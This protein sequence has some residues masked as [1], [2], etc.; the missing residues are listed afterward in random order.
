[1]SCHE[2]KN[3]L[4]TM[5]LVLALLLVFVVGDTANVCA[6]DNDDC[7]DFE[8]FA[9]DA[10]T[11]FD[12]ASK[13][14]L[15][16]LNQNVFGQKPKSKDKQGQPAQ[17]RR[18]S[19]SRLVNKDSSSS[20]SSTSTDE[21]ADKTSKDDDKKDTG[22]L[23][24]LADIAK[25][26]DPTEALFKF[27]LDKSVV[28]YEEEYAPTFKDTADL[29]TSHAKEVMDQL[30][31]VL[32]DRLNDLMD[33]C[34]FLP[35]AWYLLRHEQAKKHAYWKSSKHKYMTKVNDV[36]LWRE[37]HQAL[38][39]SDLAYV[40]EEQQVRDGLQ[41]CDNGNWELIFVDTQGNPAEPAH[42]VAVEKQMAP[43]NKDAADN[44]KKKKSFWQKAMAAGEEEESD[45]LKVMIVVRGTKTMADVL[46]DGLLEATTFKEKY[47][48]HGGIQKSGAYIVEKHIERL[49]LL[50]EVSGRSKIELLLFGHSLGCGTAAIAAMEFHD[51]YQDILSVSAVGFGCPALVSPE[52]SEQYKDIITTVV[53]DADIVPR[54][55]GSSIVNLHLEMM[56]F[57]WTKYLTEEL[58]ELGADILKDVDQW[59]SGHGTKF[60]KD[61]MG[62]LGEQIENYLDGNIRPKIQK[63]VDESIPKVVGNLEGSQRRTL[64]EKH[65]YR[66]ETELIP[67]G[68]CLHLYRTATGF[69]AAYTPCSFFD[70]IEYV[71]HLVED[72]L[73]ESGYHFALLSLLRQQLRDNNAVFDNELAR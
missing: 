33:E 63:A 1:M 54:M 24:S 51:N 59:T 16:F 22:V 43:M 53:A 36:G 27:L 14:S 38:Y 35:S 39:L 4:L 46:S 47:K 25:A 73:T 66:M 26:D 17:A 64:N 29:F 23:S 30:Q 61:V 42:F 65:E 60:A 55:S 62:K 6:N 9:H 37:L 56:S 18:Q 44:K 70:E 32:G 52:L 72:H 3:G 40:D 15:K 67:P 45:I 10:K 7:D 34:F 28:T 20:S 5:L 69:E 19:F 68:N 57:D 8:K 71:P 2:R 21:K 49:K 41:D 50:L 13:E 48:A 11:M 31:R 12:D 58:K